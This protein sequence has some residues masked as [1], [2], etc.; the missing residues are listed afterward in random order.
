MLK[1]IWPISCFTRGNP[2]AKPNATN[3]RQRWHE[4]LTICPTFLRSAR[5]GRNSSPAV[6]FVSSNTMSC[7]T[8]TRA[9]R[10]RASASFTSEPTQSVICRVE[11]LTLCGVPDAKATGKSAEG[12][13][14]RLLAR[15]VPGWQR[16]PRKRRRWGHR[17]QPPLDHV[18]AAA[19]RQHVQHRATDRD[20]PVR[21][22]AVDV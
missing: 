11:A 10:S 22:D 17:D 7:T 8:G 14:S 5:R 3:T 21:L 9:M 12:K 4:L 16:L 1:M 13:V 18:E 6:R 2:G 19:S 15:R 20:R